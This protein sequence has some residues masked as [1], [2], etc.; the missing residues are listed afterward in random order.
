MGPETKH[1]YEFG[2]YRL[3]PV[4]RILLKEGEPVSLTPK[5]FDTL[6]ALVQN[7]GDV[8]EKDD[9]MKTVWPDSFVEEGNLTVNISMLRKALGENRNERRYIVTVPGRGYRFVESVRE[10][11]EE[12]TDLLVEEH[13]RT[14]VVIEEERESV[15]KTFFFAGVGTRRLRLSWKVASVSLALVLV[16]VAAAYK[17]TTT[18]QAPTRAIALSSLQMT[19]LASWKTEPQ[20][21]AAISRFSPDGKMIAF[22]STKSGRSNLWIKQVMGGDQ[23]PITRGEWTDMTPIWSPDGDRI[24]FISNRGDQEGIWISF[25][26]GGTATLLK[27]LD[28]ISKSLRHWSTNAE[29]IYYE[30]DHNLYALDI[31][32]K[33][34]TQVT[35]FDSS[36]A[37]CRDFSVSPDEKWIAYA[38]SK[39]GQFDIW[40]MTLREGVPQ[41]VTNDAYYDLY[42]AWHPDGTR[43]IYSS[44]RAGAYQICI[45]SLNGRES[46]QITFTTSDCVAPNVAP[47]GTRILF[48]TIRDESDLWEAKA[49]GGGEFEITSEVGMETWAE[50]SPDGKSVL[51]QAANGS[52]RLID[53]AILSRSILVSGQEIRLT[54]KGFDPHWSPDGTNVA[55]L[56]LSDDRFNLWTINSAGGEEKQLTT[57][58]LK[59]R[60]FRLI[61]LNRAQDGGYSW[62]PDSSRIA[63]CSTSQDQRN[64]WTVSA[65]GS[66]H[67][68]ISNLSD[69]NVFFTRPFWSRDGT[70]IASV[71]EP[72]SSSTDGIDSWNVWI[73]DLGTVFRYPSSLSLIGWTARDNLVVA[74]TESTDGNK[75]TDVSL[76]QVSP[77]GNSLFL[78]KLKLV[79]PD[80]IEL[81]PDGRSI[82]FV[83]RQDGKDNIWMIPVGG[84]LET[85]LTANTDPRLYLST[86]TWSPD[87]R[88]ICYG[89]Q[90]RSSE[91]SMIEN[92]R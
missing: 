35:N 33:R 20:S 68:R 4:K 40:T 86:L 65:D 48:T 92:I 56:R 26:H 41:R 83:S 37:L 43:I 36:K 53:S 3:D 17:L 90:T 14:R 32:S 38:D 19:Q 10:L 25:S 44:D 30:V 73:S 8:L 81:S 11:L 84:G 28:G 64:I 51:F 82:A 34:T 58:G 80:N 31:E 61:P 1:L 87:S 13:A 69:S 63:Y 59:A 54:A 75:L 85:K 16:I 74:S 22:S 7:S 21:P 91:I 2:P 45:A 42:P 72:R 52:E 50:L 5:A 62:S 46:E 12:G 57:N 67:T 9:L 27:K 23:I 79:Y 24:A 15:G 88:A 29:T 71:L 89:K 78:G 39:D 18:R 47:D 70:R 66:I 6:L 49:D 55:F 76:L 77:A 60:S